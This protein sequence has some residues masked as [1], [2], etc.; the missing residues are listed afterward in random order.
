MNYSIEI[1][2]A[3]CFLFHQSSEED[4]LFIN[5]PGNVHYKPYQI[6]PTNARFKRDKTSLFSQSIEHCDQHIYTKLYSCSHLNDCT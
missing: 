1:L 5:Q 3:I 2:F 6:L 4:I